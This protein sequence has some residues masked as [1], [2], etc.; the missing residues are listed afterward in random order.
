M[1]DPD[2][3]VVG[4]QRCSHGSCRIAM[5]E[6]DIRKLFFQERL[7]PLEDFTG[8]VEEVLSGGHDIQVILRFYPEK[9]KDLI[10]HLPVLGRDTDDTLEYFRPFTQLFDKGSHLD[11]FRAG[12]EYGEYLD[13]E[14]FTLKAPGEALML[15]SY[16]NVLCK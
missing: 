8:Y 5:H 6:N 2:M 4:G 13:H 16:A 14:N 10:Q 7:Q 11:G 12:A 9:V 15:N 3:G 1:S